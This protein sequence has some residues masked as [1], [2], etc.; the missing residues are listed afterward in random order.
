MPNRLE[1]MSTG[2]NNQNSL[3]IVGEANAPL[4]RR[5]SP[6]SAYT[7]IGPSEQESQALHPQKPLHN[8]LDYKACH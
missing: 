2:K 6:L 8:S 5:H 4:V 3:G 1:G 7:E